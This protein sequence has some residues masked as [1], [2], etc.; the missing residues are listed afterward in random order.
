[1]KTIENNSVIL[2]DPDQEKEVVI[3]LLLETNAFVSIKTAEILTTLDKT[4]QY[5]ERKE[6]RFP[7]LHSLTHHGRRKAY[8]VQDLKNWLENPKSYQQI[9]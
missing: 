5:R 7:K 3:G 9:I 4:T 1:M 2:I 8:R 6:G